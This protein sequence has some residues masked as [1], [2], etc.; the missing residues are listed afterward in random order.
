MI[1]AGDY[2]PLVPA[3]DQFTGGILATSR[4]L[5]VLLR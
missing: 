2:K 4:A 1:Q 3:I 5:H